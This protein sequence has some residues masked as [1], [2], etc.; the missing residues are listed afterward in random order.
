[1]LAWWKE[2]AA[3]TLHGD[4]FWTGKGFGV[5]LADDDGFQVM[6][7]HSL[8]SPHNASLMLLARAGVPGLTIWLVVQ[9]GWALLISS[10]LLR[11]VRT[12]E[13][14]WSGLFLFLLAYWL[15]F[16]INGMFDVFL[17]GPMGGIWF[18]SLYGIG[19]AARHAW[20]HYPEL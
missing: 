8:R 11:S 15:A 18:W 1:R 9:L 20:K 10:A 13:Y 3:Y 7:D 17:E 14:E 5:N 16:M 12:G 2:I 6:E 19:L 4:Y